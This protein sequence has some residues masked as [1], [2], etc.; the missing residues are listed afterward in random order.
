MNNS[1]HQTDPVVISA[2]KRTPLGSFQGELSP[3]SASDLGAEAVK[4]TIEQSGISKSAVSDVFVGCV[5]QA[6]QGQAPARQTALKADLDKSA[7]CTTVNK[8]CGSGMQA[9][10]LA[11]D[12]LYVNPDN[13]IIA[14]GIESMTNAPY[15]L[16]KARQGLRIGHGNIVDHMFL[17]GLEDAYSKKTLMGN[18][19]DKTAE[20]YH[21]TREEQDDFAINSVQKALKA[22]QEGWFD[23]EIVNVTVK[24]RKNSYDVS[25][26]EQPRRSNIDKIRSMKPAFSENGTITAANASSI[27]DGAAMALMMRESKSKALNVAPQARIVATA[28]Y[29]QE[30]QWFTLAPIGAISSIYNKTGWQEKD[31]DLYE[32]NEAFAVV[33]MATMKEHN[34]PPEKVNIHGGACALGHPIGA[35]GCRIVA[36]LL[37][38][39]QRNKLKRGIACLCIGGGE[40]VAI[41]IEC[42]S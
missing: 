35:S 12:N 30:P 14:G 34:L 28:S 21:F 1:N 6:G 32:I 39:L 17:D 8:M 23:N 40:A 25:S 26:D 33:T 15:L 24:D 10:M 36:T 37:Y 22:Q 29:A 16:P 27:S 7:S 31:V 20:K 13:V 18:F 9:M 42:Y 4:G 11:H 38:A 19:A 2:I 3:C 41:A 5:L